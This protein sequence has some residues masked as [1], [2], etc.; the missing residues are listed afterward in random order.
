MS[1]QTTSIADDKILVFSI[2]VPGQPSPYQA[3]IRYEDLVDV[4][5][6]ANQIVVPV[7]RYD[8]KGTKNMTMNVSIINRCTNPGCQKSVPKLIRCAD[9]F[10]V[11]YCGQ[12]CLNAH[13]KAHLILCG[14]PSLPSSS[15]GEEKKE[16]D[17]CD[18]DTSSK[19]E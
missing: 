4:A 3:K 10:E 19:A 18:E 7:V 5:S 6:K 17:F 12:E 9:C 13:R 14:K 11:A 1:Q 2:H 8:L 15:K 16:Y